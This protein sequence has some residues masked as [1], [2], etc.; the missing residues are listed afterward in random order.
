VRISVLVSTF[1]RP[2]ANKM[3]HPAARSQCARRFQQ[4]DDASTS[5]ASELDTDL[6]PDLFSLVASSVSE[7]VCHEQAQS[8][9]QGQRTRLDDAV[10]L[11][12]IL[13]IDEAG[14]IKSAFRLVE[15]CN[16]RPDLYGVASSN[17]RTRIQNRVNYWKNFPERY[18]VRRSELGIRTVS[19]KKRKP[20]SQRVKVASRPSKREPTPPS[21]KK[22]SGANTSSG[23][24]R[25]RQSEEDDCDHD[26]DPDERFLH[27]FAELKL[28]MSSARFSM[29]NDLNV[30][31]ETKDRVRGTY[32]MRAATPCP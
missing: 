20:P 19:A 3:V 14:G 8:T 29:E 1:S 15:I 10:E 31:S 24:P 9:P 22:P 13:D 6:E 30:D 7:D 26:C 12:L 11:Q 17:Q 18:Y 21:P 2:W 16:S 28:N 32:G 27:R 25:R 4:R 5:T 23:R